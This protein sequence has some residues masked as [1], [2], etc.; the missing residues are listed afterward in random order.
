MADS[1]FCYGTLR[2]SAVIDAVL[3]MELEGEN[4]FLADYALYRFSKVLYPGIV[5]QSGGRVEG[6]VYHGIFS[7]LL[8]EL[9]QYE[10]R[11]YV[12]QIHEITLENGTVCPAHVYITRQEFLPELTSEPW[13]Y[14]TFIEKGLL[15]KYLQ[16]LSS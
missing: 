2:S 9:D 8:N 6:V 7:E 12:R 3:G 13:D 4:G 14:N 10:G 5:E 1:L 11:Q 15:V 16:Y